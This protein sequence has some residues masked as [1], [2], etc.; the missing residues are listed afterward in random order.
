MWEEVIEEV[1]VPCARGRAAMIFVVS[2]KE[3]LAATADSFQRDFENDTKE[4]TPDLKILWL[5]QVANSAAG[6]GEDFK[7]AMSETDIPGSELYE[8]GKNNY[9]DEV[10][11]ACLRDYIWLT[12]DLLSRESPSV[13]DPAKPAFKLVPAPD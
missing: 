4:I 13:D 10:L 8:I 1:A 5:N 6:A 3:G 11:G 9:Y 12:W 2:S 7:R